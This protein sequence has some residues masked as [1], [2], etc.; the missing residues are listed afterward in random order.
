MTIMAAE[1]AGGLGEGASVASGGIADAFNPA[2]TQTQVVA[3]KSAAPKA[4]GPLWSPPQSGRSYGGGGASAPAAQTTQ[5][6]TASRPTAK[7]TATA[8]VPKSLG[9]RR[10]APIQSRGSKRASAARNAFKPPKITG[11][12][13][14]G[15]HNL[16]VG[17]FVL[18]VVLIGATPIL[19]RQPQNG[20]LYIP[21]D[22]VRLSAVS[23]LFFVL[24][25]LANGEKGAR[26]AAAFGGLVTLGVL[27][28]AAGSIKAIG[29]IFA[30]AQASGGQPKTAAA[31]TEAVATPT[32]TPEPLGGNPSA[33]AMG[34]LG[35]TLSKIPGI[36]GEK[37]STSGTTPPATGTPGVISV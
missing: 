13:G 19:M 22:F 7:K 21:N 33:D 26:F 12:G 4:S 28:N 34:N 3:R 15:A 30:N 11:S 9:P 27:Y 37:P 18:C 8:P 1:A 23:A 2:T 10:S 14:S 25:L 6:K 35:D 5:L 20:H 36:L 24:A 31:G 32:Y 29:N 16:V 17:E